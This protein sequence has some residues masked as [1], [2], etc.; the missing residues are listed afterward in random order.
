ME[1]MPRVSDWMSAVV[2][3]IGHDI[4]ASKARTIMLN[5]D[6]RHLPVLKEGKLVGLISDRDIRVAE[7]IRGP[8]ELAVGDIMVPDP[9]VVG[10]DAPIDDV[11][12]HMLAHKFGSAV[13]Q[14]SSG[15][16][17]G[18]FTTIDAVRALKELLRRQCSGRAA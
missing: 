7:C 6:I 12:D 8:S 11:L 5:H 16:L 1:R 15:K 18:I 13:I 4:P 17:V 9:F 10:P 3:T 2:H 14:E